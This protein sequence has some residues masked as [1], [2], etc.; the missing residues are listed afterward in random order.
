MLRA[1]SWEKLG[2]GEL[3]IVGNFAFADFDYWAWIKLDFGLPQWSSSATTDVWG[4]KT[5]I[6]DSDLQKIWWDISLLVEIKKKITVLGK[7]LTFLFF[8]M[9]LYQFLSRFQWGCRRKSGFRYLNLIPWKW[10]FLNPSRWRLWKMWK[11][12]LTSQSRTSLKSK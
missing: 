11:F 4:K 12:P 2:R 3:L 8:A 10:K 7:F 6:R 5:D 1:V 9:K